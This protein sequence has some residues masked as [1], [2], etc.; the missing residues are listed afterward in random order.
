MGECWR[1][2]HCNE[3]GHTYKFCPKRGQQGQA[4]HSNRPMAPGRVYVTTREEATA[5]PNVIQGMVSIRGHSVEVLF[6]SGATHSFITTKLILRLSRCTDRT[7]IM[8]KK[9]LPHGEI[10][11]Q[12]ST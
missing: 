1:C 9:A 2:Y 12:N 10:C 8:L 6:D 3:L 4:S 7:P 5:S 11:H